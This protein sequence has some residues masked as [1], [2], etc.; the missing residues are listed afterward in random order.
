MLKRWYGNVY[1]TCERNYQA[2]NN[3]LAKSSFGRHVGG[4]EHA[5]QH[6]GQY[7]SCYFVE[8]SKY[9]KISLLNAIIFMSSVK[10]WQH[11]EYNSS[12]EG[13]IGH[14]TS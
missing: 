8:K 13:S 11:Q 6:G 7:K 12:F 2:F 3:I 14:V 10:F 1:S 9:P 4:Q 5:L